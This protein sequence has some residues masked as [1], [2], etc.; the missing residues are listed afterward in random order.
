MHGFQYA[1]C[2]DP[3]LAEGSFSDEI[4]ISLFFCTEVQVS[5]YLPGAVL[6]KFRMHGPCSRFESNYCLP[7]VRHC[8]SPSSQLYNELPVSFSSEPLS[9]TTN[10]STPH[11]YVG[12]MNKPASAILPHLR[13]IRL[14]LRFV[15]S[16][17]RNNHIIKP[18]RCCE[19]ISAILPHPQV[20]AL[21]MLLQI[22]MEI[23][24]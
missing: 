8:H 18:T 12:K 4:K 15:N 13:R 17:Q 3:S 20:H 6:C 7:V 24:Q 22:L 23:I 16:S 11:V 1:C 19:L 14:D 5:T 10:S 2:I 21:I 9:G